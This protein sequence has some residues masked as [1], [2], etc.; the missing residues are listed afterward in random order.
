MSEA[1]DTADPGE[2]EHEEA[3]ETE[4]EGG[5]DGDE[6]GAD[7]GEEDGERK[8][9]AKAED[10]EKRAHNQ[11]GRAARERSRRVAAEKRAADLETRLERVERSAGGQDADE[12]L[13]L[14]AALPDSEDDP[15]GDIAAVKRAL[16]MFRARQV[17][18]VEQTGQQ[19]QI[20]RQIDALRGAMSDAENDFSGDHPDYH[21]AASFYRRARVEE[22]QEAG[23]SGAF[24]QRKLAD[25]LFGVVRMAIEAN[26]D[27]AER[28]YSLAKRR[29]FKAGGKLADAKLEAL[30]RGTESG[31][32]PQS[33]AVGGVLS[34]GDVAKLDGAARDKAWAK[35]REREKVSK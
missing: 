29:G 20:E 8:P 31:A 25:D 21:D 3:P 34:W 27:P 11:A 2:G 19:R 28:V 12:L 18:E 17:A 10:W 4:R 13:E 30:R 26:L 5:G 9:A 22:L 15:V 35:L 33:R 32:R 24:L 14:I 1:P 16:K 6:Q 23:Y 7:D